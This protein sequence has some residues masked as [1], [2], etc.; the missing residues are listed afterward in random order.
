MNRKCMHCYNYFEVCIFLTKWLNQDRNA[1]NLQ[2]APSFSC[3]NTAELE[4][5]VIV[6][7]QVVY[8]L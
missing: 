4:Y 8:T 7:I 5:F 6:F 3:G 1:M 2:Y